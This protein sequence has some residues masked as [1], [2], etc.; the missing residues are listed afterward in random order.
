[1]RIPQH[2]MKTEAT[3]TAYGRCALFFNEREGWIIVI[4]LG[5]AFAVR[6]YLVFHTFVICNDGVLYIKMS[7]L[8][9]E[10]RA[11][12]AFGLLFFNLYP[13]V[14]VLFQNLFH[15]WEFS[16]QMVST[17]FGS[18]TIVP[19]YFLVRSLF[20]RT[21]AFTAS[22]LFVFHPYLVRFSAE[23]IR[24]P[25][26]WFF[27]MMALWVGWLAISR[28]RL[29]LFAVTGL[30]GAISFLIRPEGVFVVPLVAVWVFLNDWRTLKSTYRRR[31]LSALIVLLTVPVLLSP[32]MLYLEK[33]TGHWQW[34]RAD[35]ILDIATADLTMES[36]ERDFHKLEL[37]PW[38][39]TSEGWV[40]FVRLRSFLSL[41]T[42]HGIGLVILEMMRTFVKAMHPLLLILILVGAIKRKGVEYH[43]REELFLL[44]AVVMFFLIVLRY[45]TFHPYMGKRHMLPPVMLSLAWVGVAI[46]EVEHRVRKSFLIGKFTGGRN[47]S[48]RSVHWVLLILVI[49]VLLPKTLTSQRADKIPLKEAGIWIKEH[50]PRDPVIM[51]EG[52]LV[53]VAFYGEG[54]FLELSRNQDPYV[55]AKEKQVDFLIVNEKGIERSHPDLIRSLTSDHF[56]EEVVIGEPSGDYVI[57]IYSLKP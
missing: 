29:W 9:S 25:T 32:A 56:C 47:T 18:V 38:D 16:G 14:T 17:V 41:A 23:V 3:E 15:D 34:A 53:H 46:F 39:D 45:G 5:L 55:Y 2:D 28:E 7:K 44:S 30:F 13:L 24:G 6:L 31:I 40:E 19:F 42:E 21:V 35:K 51:G 11:G 26:F 10:G 49:L 4:L 20:S 43:R 52:R 27:F 8:I 57:R 36:I 12:E 22:M 48:C 33:T 50:G 37:K 54:T 1:M